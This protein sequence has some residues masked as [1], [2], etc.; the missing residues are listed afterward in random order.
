MKPVEFNV[1][2]PTFQDC[3]LSLSN[4]IS[5]SVIS[6]L[7]KIEKQES[8]DKFVQKYSFNELDVAAID[9]FPGTEPYYYFILEF[10][11]AKSGSRRFRKIFIT[12]RLYGGCIECATAFSV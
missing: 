5:L 9:T 1:S 8:W 4:E 6:K 11:V 2:S 7:E 12:A 3:L 10:I